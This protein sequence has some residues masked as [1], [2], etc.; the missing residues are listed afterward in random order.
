MYVGLLNYGEKFTYTYAGSNIVPTPT[1][2]ENGVITWSWK[3]LY[4]TAIDLTAQLGRE[5]FVGA[6][7]VKLPEASVI[8]AE[9]LV[10]GALA[11]SYRAQAGKL[12]GGD[13][14][15]PV[16]TKGSTVVLRLYAD[17]VDL[18]VSEL[19]VLGAY[20]DEKPLLWPTPKN[21]EAIGGYVKIKSIKSAKC[22]ADECFAVDFL[23][24]RL[25]EK[26][27]KATARCGATVVIE[28]D[29][30]YKKERF[31]VETTENE[32][33]IKAASRLALLWG[34]DSLVQLTDKKGFFRAN[35]D[36]EP[37]CELRG[38]HMGLPHK[39]QFE[40][41]RRLFRY[42]LVP[43]RY[44]MI[45]VEFAGAMRFDR[46]PKIAEKWMEAIN[47]F[48]EGKQPALPHSGMV[49]GQSILEKDEVRLFLSYAR[50][51]GIEIVPEVQSL[52]HVQ[53]IT[54]AYPE[55]A[56]IDVN[57]KYTEDERREDPRPS[58][59]YDH[60]YCPSIPRS[61]EII[62]DLFDEIIE[63][64]KPE[65][66]VHIGHDEVYHIGVCPRCKD[67]DPS[68]IFAE[69]VNEIYNY[70]TAKGYKVMM[71]ADM[72]HSPPTRKY[73]TY[74]AID[75]IPKDI[76]LLD[77][78]WYFNMN[79]DI[80]DELI[81]HGFTVG[82]GNL[83]SPN[84]PRF[85]KRLYKDGVVGGVFATWHVIREQ[86]LG[87]CGKFFDAMYLGAALWDGGYDSR[88]RST[89]NHIISKYIQPEKRDLIR[90]TYN[91]NGYKNK[92]LPAFEGETKCIPAELLQACKGA[93]ALDHGEI[94]VGERYD[95]LVFAHTTLW[96]AVVKPWYSYDVVGSY[97]VEY[98]D[99]TKEVI[100]L[101]YSKHVMRYT[102]AYAK[103]MLENI[104]RHT[105]LQMTWTTDPVIETK[106]SR[107]DDVCVCGLVWENPNP[108]KIIA[109]ISFD[110]AEN[111][112]S[113]PV[114]VEIRGYNK[115]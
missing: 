107:G 86:Q 73:E 87:Y 70:V 112:I 23:T 88:N 76:L 50:E 93:V 35:I 34:V 64:A 31:T 27:G 96:D 12:V 41:T 26:L 21:M 108:D 63:V 16:G 13:L 3:V 66:Y 101:G 77:F 104:Y 38:F 83:Y 111:D 42:V 61:L 109:S 89:Y 48:N 33:K 36:D 30:S 81:D 19:C 4:K 20:D 90:G 49:G 78:V 1:S 37:T 99:G 97:T 55:I 94:K 110:R 8:A 47:N 15:I 84:F 102:E 18:S 43:M 11:G 28:K 74:R 92:K 105:A 72:L 79:N 10:D 32:I 51:L 5:C 29:E 106:D 40:L 52:G 82:I 22:D 56:E 60:C 54:Y 2:E 98:E 69:H 103:P 67:R 114:L 25:E 57:G 100:E 91:V 59:Y 58:V 115:K 44:N 39:S 80:E 7:S 65:R 68:D 46:H 9:V 113:R 6:V 95:R 14:N 62:K 75:K 17:V 71:W 85:E 53:F 24:E 45:V